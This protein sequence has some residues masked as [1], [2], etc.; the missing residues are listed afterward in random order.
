MKTLL[1]EDLPDALELDR[2]TMEDIRGGMLRLP[3]YYAAPIEPEDLSPI[4]IR[5]G[6]YRV[7]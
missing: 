5:A 4:D 7:W 2:E 1:I 6:E 3:G